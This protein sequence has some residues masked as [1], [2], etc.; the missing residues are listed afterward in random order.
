MV[1]DLTMYFFICLLLQEVSQTGPFSPGLW[2]GG[3]EPRSIRPH[4]HWKCHV[5]W[6]NSVNVKRGALFC[7]EWFFTAFVDIIFI[8]IF[9]QCY[10]CELRF[11]KDSGCNRIECMCGAIM[12]YYCRHDITDDPHHF[13]GF[14]EPELDKWVFCVFLFSH[15]RPT[16]IE[17][18]P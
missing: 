7:T 16:L 15:R 5:K 11:V 13:R 2:W 12:C 17:K 4:H 6:A 18:L 14:G 1:L 9:R 3:R 10:E 8:F